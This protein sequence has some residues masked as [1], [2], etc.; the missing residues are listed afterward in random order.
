MDLSKHVQ[1]PKDFVG[2]AKAVAESAV[3]KIRIPAKI[4]TLTKS[5]IGLRTQ[6]G[7]LLAR[8]TGTSPDNAPHI[9][10]DTSSRSWMTC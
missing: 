1:P 4:I 7:K 5:V 8:L 6:H 2:L 9:R 10:I 3:P